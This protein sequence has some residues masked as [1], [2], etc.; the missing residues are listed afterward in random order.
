MNIK[1]SQKI[2]PNMQHVKA[3]SQ[4]YLKEK[5]YTFMEGN[6]VKLFCLPS[7]K[8]SSLKGRKFFPFEADTFSERACLVCRKAKQKVIKVDAFP[9]KKWW[10]IHQIYQI[11]FTLVLLNS[12]IPC[13]C[14]QCRPRSV[15]LKKPTD[16]DLHCLSL[17]M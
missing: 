6:S 4:C 13:P 2:L 17:S 14:K 1:K 16:L 12:D 7:I 11:T 15:G 9:C 3:A 8:E 10:K 5:R